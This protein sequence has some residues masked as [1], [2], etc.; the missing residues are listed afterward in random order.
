MKTKITSGI[1]IMLLFGLTVRAQLLDAALM[2]NY[3]P[4][5]VSKVFEVVKHTP[6]SVQ[7]QLELAMRYQQIDNTV[8]QW[9]ME[10][11]PVKEIDSLQNSANV[12]LYAIL[13]EKQ[14]ESHA[15]NV[16]K[17]FAAMAAEG[18]L[19]YLQQEYK[20][21]SAALAHLSTW[22]NHRYSY[23]Y[24]A[25]LWAQSNPAMEKHINNDLAKTYDLF[26]FYPTLYSKKYVDGYLAKLKAIK[27]VADAVLQKIKMSFYS[28]IKEDKYTD[29]SKALTDMTLYYL[30]DTAYYSKLRYD[31]LTREANRLSATDRNT[32]L[33]QHHIS[34]V[35]YETVFPMVQQ[36]NFKNALLQYTYA[37]YSPKK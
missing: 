32:L 30:P 5:V 19:Q 26:A 6:L 23:M 28:K 11:K 15:L 33:H 1:L 16:S 20:P 2:K 21:D 37:T 25:F 12:I 10:G 14:R 7:Q 9:L 8:A 13:N 36:K 29:W 27:P 18:E 3:P 17:Q 34:K 22:L 24:Q 35:A 4:G 31:D